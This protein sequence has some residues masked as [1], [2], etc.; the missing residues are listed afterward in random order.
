MA[1]DNLDTEI[2]HR[3]E[4]LTERQKECLALAADGLSSKEIARTLGVSPSTVDNHI[5]QAL[6][7]LEVHSRRDAIRLLSPNRRHNGLTELS[8]QFGVASRQSFLP[9]LGG[10]SN[11]ATSSQR[12]LQIFGI[13][14][15]SVL[16]V[17]A[18]ILT[19]SG[20]IHLLEHWAGGQSS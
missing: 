14:I 16:V 5:L 15:I 7:K 4:R 9:P 18:V 12:L 8:K 11:Q 6:Q 10:I 1:N 17:I 3:V 20:A 2:A 13:G 19:I